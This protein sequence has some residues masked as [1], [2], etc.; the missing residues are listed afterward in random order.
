MEDFLCY[1]PRVRADPF[2]FAEVVEGLGVWSVWVP[3]WF[4]LARTQ[5]MAH[6]GH[7]LVKGTSIACLACRSRQCPMGSSIDKDKVSNCSQMT[8]R[9]CQE[10]SECICYISIIKIFFWFVAR[11][12]SGPKCGWQRVLEIRCFCCQSWLKF[13]VGP[14][15]QTEKRS[16]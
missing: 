8:A 6:S 11:Q 3:Q 13:Q 16:Q 1:C 14:L 5:H 12:A 4:C 10:C 7:R 9:I 2:A 15:R